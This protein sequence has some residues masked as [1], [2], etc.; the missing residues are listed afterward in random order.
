MKEFWNERFGSP[1]FIYGTQPNEFFKQELDKIQP[2]KLLLPAEGEGRN[3]VYAATKGWEVTAFDYA[4]AGKKKAF[5]LAKE[6]NVQF[7]YFI[8][9]YANVILP[10]NH[11][12]ALALIYAHT[13]NWEQVYRTLLRALKPGGVL[14]LEVFNKKQIH[15][16]SGGPKALPLLVNASELKTILQDFSSIDCWEDEITLGEGNFHTG[17]ADVVRCVAKK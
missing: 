16:D 7:D 1:T 10:E 11:F 3:A 12:D 5:L 8:A 2:G 17:K 14:I 15:N 6:N 4:E 13:P 9:D